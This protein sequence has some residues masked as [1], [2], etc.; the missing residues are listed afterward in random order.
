MTK[1]VIIED[2]LLASN[3]LTFLLRKIRP[4]WQLAGIAESIETA[5][6]MLHDTEANLIFS[7]ICLSDGLCFDI[8]ERQFTDLPVIFTTAYDDYAIKAFKTNSVDYLLK[9]VDEGDLKKAVEKYEHN[10]LSRL[11]SDNVRK[12]GEAYAGN[13][14]HNRFLVHV[15]DRF[16]YVKTDDISCFYSEEK[17]TFIQTFSGKRYIVDYSLGQLCPMLDPYNF[18]LV[19]RNCIASIKGVTQ[20]VRYFAGRLRMYLEPECPVD[21]II[22]RSRT[23][24]VL[25]WLNGEP[26]L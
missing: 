19:S 4:E 9:P 21:V 16:F 10:Y 1:Y 24:D 23:A 12:A 7:D 8:F 25:K 3:E 18:M 15:G 6:Q 5:C 26:C 13:V 22:S 17:C 20:C 11:S 2:E 14:I